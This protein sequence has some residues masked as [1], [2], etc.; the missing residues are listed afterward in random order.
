VTVKVKPGS[1]TAGISNLEGLLVVA[2]RQRAVD[3]AANAAV[4]AAVAGWL[5]I[6]PSRISIERGARGRTKR[7]A[8]DGL[9]EPTFATALANTTVSDAARG[10]VRLSAG[11]NFPK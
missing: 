11:R 7:L 2:V 10:P 5:A 1:R 9:D 6:A 3:G 8:I 4:V